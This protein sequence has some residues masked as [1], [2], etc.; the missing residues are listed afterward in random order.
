MWTRSPSYLRNCRRG[1]GRY[2]GTAVT[3]LVYRQQI[4]PVVQGGAVAMDRIFAQPAGESG[5][6]S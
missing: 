4:R 1:S 2:S 5:T 6:A 3:E